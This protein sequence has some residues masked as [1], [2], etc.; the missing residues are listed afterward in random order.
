M[1][2]KRTN[3]NI[4][5]NNL[6]V[7][8]IFMTNIPYYE[9]ND[10]FLEFFKNLNTGN[11]VI[12]WREGAKIINCMDMGMTPFIFL[13]FF[14]DSHINGFDVDYENRTV[15]DV[16]SNVGDT[17]LYF[18]GEGA[19]VYGYEP[20]KHLYDYSLEI[21]ELNPDIKDKLNFFNYGVSDKRGKIKIDAMDSTSAYVHSEDNYE[22]EVITINDILKANNIE[23]DILK[24]DC[25]GCEFN[26]ILN[27]DLSEFKDIIFEH[28]SIFVGKSYTL[29]TE[30]LEEEGFEFETLTTINQDF[31]DIGLIHAYK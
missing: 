21:K 9:P 24:I 3:K 25:E 7:F 16:G 10:E 11:H 28:H 23:P 6:P 20:V 1:K 2:L 29:L 22:V 26:I 4:T 15:I 27:T 5:F 30:K 12:T 18:A 14:T 8:N 13:E 17:G 19:T 31:N